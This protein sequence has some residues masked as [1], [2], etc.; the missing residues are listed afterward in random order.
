L[1]HTFQYVKNIVRFQRFYLHCDNPIQPMAL[2]AMAAGDPFSNGADP[3]GKG[4]P[5]GR[6]THEVVHEV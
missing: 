4:D 6:E 3:V 2:R 5:F 1:P